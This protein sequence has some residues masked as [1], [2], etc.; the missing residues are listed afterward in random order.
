MSVDTG[1]AELFGRRRF[2]IRPG[3]GRIKAL[4][5]RLGHPEQTFRAIH[6]VGTNG[7]GSTAAFLSAILTAAGCHNGLFTSPHLVSYA[8][9][10][11]IDGVEIA[12]Q[13]LN[14]LT[15]EILAAAGPEDTFF[16]LTTALACC[17]F[18]ECN[19]ELALFEAGMGGKADATAAIPAAATVITPISMDHQQWLGNDIGT[20]A[21]EKVAITEA[22]TL[23]ICA[24]QPIEARTVITRYCLENTI[25][26]RM[27]GDQ[28]TADWDTDG[29]LSYHGPGIS[30]NGLTPGIPG[31][32]Q[33][34]NAA[35][36]LATAELLAE[37]G[38]SISHTALRDGI[39]TAC[40]PG[41]MERFC[42]PGNA[43]VIL[44]GAHNPAGAEA[45]AESLRLDHPGRRI[46]LVLGVM[47]DKELEGLLFPL[48]PLAT[49]IFTVAPDQERALPADRLAE[50]CA[51][52]GFPATASGT[53]EQGFEQA[54]HYCKADDLIVVAGSL[55]T[56]GETRALL[57]SQTCN[58]VRG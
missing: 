37:S 10:F 43:E 30:L 46:I 11:R 3:I 41:R 56:V 27:A 19:I 20:I 26:L 1:L 52:S 53:I 58:A 21:R 34:W 32:Y 14:L 23:A 47:A 9:R 6:I 55:F 15:A 2:A 12:E 36:A 31:R 49:R 28:F 44:D 29:T 4:L 24:P 5:A 17:W 45:L 39:S 57:T 33:Q 8:E 16:E 18:A 50:L 7:K 54:R 35:C 48:L 42:L 51:T 13:R 38:I 22:G 40:W 25:Q